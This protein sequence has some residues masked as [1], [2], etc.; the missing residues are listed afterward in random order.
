MSYGKSIEIFLA[1]GNAE[2]LITAEVSNWNGKAIKIPRL[3]LPEC[4]REDVRRA[5][6]YF[7]FCQEDDGTDS[8][9]IGEAENIYDR[10]H[11]HIHLLNK[12]KAHNAHLQAAWNKY[13]AQSFDYGILCYCSLEE[14]FDIEQ[15]YISVLKPEYNLTLNVVANTGHPCSEEAKVKISNTLKERYRTGEITT[16]KQEHNW[17][18][19]WVYDITTYTLYKHFK[20]ITDICRDLKYNRTSL[21]ATSVLRDK[22][23]I[24]F[25]E[26]DDSNIHNRIDEEFKKCKSSF[27]TY[28]ISEENGIYTY[29]RTL[30]ECANHVGLYLSSIQK[31]SSA[32]KEN[33]YIPKKFPN[34]KIYFSNI[35][36]P[37]SGRSV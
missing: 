27:G 22:Y 19:C 7:L 31:H 37:N 8:V 15:Y 20:N 10:L 33:P 6:V 34:V 12:N 16:Y 14:Q 30:K 26:L 36:F 13:G 24:M 18:E 1:N 5:G 32:T 4:T 29:H 25:E 21:N 11:S 3:E 28:L 2:S 23:C 35:F 9:Y 17:K